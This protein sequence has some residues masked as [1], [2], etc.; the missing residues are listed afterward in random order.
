MRELEYD[1]YGHEIDGVSD[2]DEALI[3]IGAHAR[4]IYTKKSSF[5][6]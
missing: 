6:Y 4:S 1:V 3:E 5:N 2:M